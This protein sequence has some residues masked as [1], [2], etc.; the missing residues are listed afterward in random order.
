MR[1]IPACGMTTV[2]DTRDFQIGAVSAAWPNSE[3]SVLAPTAAS[4]ASN[5]PPEMPGPAKPRFAART[6]RS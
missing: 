6:N 3:K 4:C 1:H 5:A 2:N